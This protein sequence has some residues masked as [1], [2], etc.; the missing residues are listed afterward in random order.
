VDLAAP[1]AAVPAEQRWNAAK[2]PSVP[3]HRAYAAALLPG[4]SAVGAG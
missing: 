3:V 2:H 4:L 1:L